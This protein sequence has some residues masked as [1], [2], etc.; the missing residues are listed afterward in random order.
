MRFLVFTIL[1]FACHQKQVDKA[2]PE[3][4]SYDS[5]SDLI[6]FDTSINVN[7]TNFKL[8]LQELHEGGFVIEFKR[9]NKT[10]TRDTICTEHFNNIEFSDF[11]HDSY[12]DVFISI[13]TNVPTQILYLFDKQSNM[14]RQVAGYDEI[15]EAH[16]LEQN[17]NYYYSYRRAGCADFNWISELFYIEQF[18]IIRLAY[19][20]GQGC[21]ANL[22]DPEGPTEFIYIYE[23]MDNQEDKMHL[24]AKYPYNTCISEF[25]DKWSFLERYWNRNYIKFKPK[26]L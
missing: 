17:E 5:S 21:K 7:E 25:D 20:D 6:Y 9:E 15:S 16:S 26:D 4:F 2:I 14:F 3:E 8:F 19:I 1:L 10:L 23:I 12:Q 11:N 22:S 18:E 13:L 24:V